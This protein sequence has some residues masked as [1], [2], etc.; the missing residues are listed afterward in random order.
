MQ[1]TVIS[2]VPELISYGS[3]GMVTISVSLYDIEFQTKNVLELVL[4]TLISFSIATNELIKGNV[5]E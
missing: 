5:W 4:I 2:L 1:L 3:A